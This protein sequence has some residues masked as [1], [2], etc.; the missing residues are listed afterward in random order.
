MLLM[1]VAVAFAL[2]VIYKIYRLFSRISLMI[3]LLLLVGSLVGGSS[4]TS[5]Q[6]GV[7]AQGTSQAGIPSR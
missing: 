5:C 1:V 4:L 7:G 3:R 6:R 2:L